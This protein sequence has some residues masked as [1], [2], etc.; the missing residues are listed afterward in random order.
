MGG[1]PEEVYF[2]LQRVAECTEGLGEPWPMVQHA[3]LKA[4]AYRPSRAEAL[5]A[6]AAHYRAEREWQLGYFFA[7]AA[8]RIPM[9]ENGL[10]VTEDVYTISALDEQAICA[11]WLG[12]HEESFTIFQQLLAHEDL[13]DS[14]RERIVTNRD[15]AVPA[16][17][18]A[19]GKY[20]KTVA[21]G[22][23]GRSPYSDV[24]ATLVGGPDRRITE[25]SLNSLLQY[26]TDIDKIGRF[27]LIDAGLSEFDRCYLADR[28]PFL[29]MQPASGTDLAD[30]RRTVHSRF[31]LHFG[32]DWQLF[33]PEPLVGRLAA[34]LEREPA[35][36]QVAV[37]FDDADYAVNKSAPQSIVRSHPNTGRYTVTARP[38][39][40]PAMYD[41]TRYDASGSAAKESAALAEII[42][43]KIS[44][45]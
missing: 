16:M 11:Y 34:V 23:L 20:P 21:H 15:F 18:E 14:T 41:T 2:S 40:G 30:I 19:G 9:P 44:G 12:K 45:R 39:H 4:W 5:C 37:N 33:A 10:F 26:C 22:L 25:L 36:Y 43:A 31:W 6:I 42:A 24:T 1:W 35:V 3:L 8:A 13:D 17:L 27:L 29:E 28:Y 32:A 38:A 7:E